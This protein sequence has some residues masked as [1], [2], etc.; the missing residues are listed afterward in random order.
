MYPYHTGGMKYLT[1]SWLFVTM[2]MSENGTI[3]KPKLDMLP[4]ITGGI[5]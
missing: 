2:K 5:L 3:I 4:P 1:L